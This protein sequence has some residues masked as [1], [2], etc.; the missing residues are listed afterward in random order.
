M[1]YLS[2]YVRY[3]VLGIAAA[4][5]YSLRLSELMTN[6]SAFVFLACATMVV[7]LTGYSLAFRKITVYEESLVIPEEHHEAVQE[8][9]EDKRQPRTYPGQE[10]YS[11]IGPVGQALLG[12][13]HVCIIGLGGLGVASA[14]L[15]A[16]AGIGKLSLFDESTVSIHDLQDHALFTEADIGN[17]KPSAAQYSI[18][19]INPDVR[20][21]AH[22]VGVS[23][24]NKG[25]VDADL[26]LVCTNSIESIKFIGR[27][28]KSRKIPYIF[29]LITMKRG[30]IKLME[31]E[32]FQ[33]IM[34]SL[35]IQPHH[36]SFS[37][38]IHMG[39]GIMVTLSIQQ[40][41]A[42]HPPQATIKYNAWTPEIKLIQHKK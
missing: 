36:T 5:T 41:L 25:L 42:R 14:E 11:G 22:R 15:L 34:Q 24:D 8:I 6:I 17:P 21:N 2:Y 40:L 32:S 33:Q 38:T 35:P 16:R 39:S 26:V 31:D 20:V 18:G 10:A 27:H 37:P 1:E 19:C 29:S 12:E 30:Y 23:K 28:C 7:V 13:K 9:S 3:T 4:V